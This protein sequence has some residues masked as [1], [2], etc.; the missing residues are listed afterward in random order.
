MTSMF[1]SLL[2]NLTQ[3]LEEINTLPDSTQYQGKKFQPWASNLCP[4]QEILYQICTHSTVALPDQRG[5]GLKVAGLAAACL[6]TRTP[7][8][9][10]RTTEVEATMMIEGLRGGD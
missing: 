9:H 6:L 2:Q 3:G 10:Y 4:Y 8:S 7:P 5:K 1:F